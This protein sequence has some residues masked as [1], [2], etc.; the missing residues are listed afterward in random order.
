MLLNESTR[1]RPSNP[2]S[3]QPETVLAAPPR[4]FC[5]S[6]Q[7]A[8]EPGVMPRVLGL[9][10]KRNLVPA[11]WVSHVQVPG[12]GPGELTIDLQVR[13]ID[14]DLTAYLAR[15]LAQI[16]DVRAVLTSE[17]TGAGGAEP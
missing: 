6:I 13:G 16:A 8:A 15:C 5:F 11:R 10:A 1:L 12:Q 4:I 2:R 9:F 14:P 3:L 7:A 17:K